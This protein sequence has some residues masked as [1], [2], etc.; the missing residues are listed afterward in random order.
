VTESFSAE[1]VSAGQGGHA[2]VVPKEVA[3]TFSAKR[4]PVL[5]H[6]NGIEYRTRIMVYGGKSYLGLRKDL[7][8][9]AAARAGD[10]VQIDLVEAEPEEHQQA[11]A[12]DPPELS[13]ALAAD[14]A[15]QAAYDALPFTHRQEYARWIDEA[16]KSETRAERVRKT[17]TRLARTGAPP[18]SA[19]T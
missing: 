18:N 1:I 5:A 13:A 11:V 15:A 16:K 3:A 10:I 17:I 12:V 2:V 8:R 7:L 9:A 6:I 4:V 14:P 19:E